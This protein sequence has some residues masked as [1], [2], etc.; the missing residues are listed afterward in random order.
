[1]IQLPIYPAVARAAKLES[2]VK[3]L[4]NTDYSGKVNNVKF[5][6]GKEQLYSS[7]LKAMS[8]WQ[9]NE[10][11]QKDIPIIFDFRIFPSNTETIY[12][13]TFDPDLTVFIEGACSSNYPCK[14]E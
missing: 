1:M 8:Q 10:T 2:Q 11:M 9:F 4:I 7:V 14:N 6:S 12:R 3:C 13:I 5:V